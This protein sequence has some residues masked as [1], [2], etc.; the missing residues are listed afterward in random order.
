M[1]EWVK[2][3]CSDLGSPV[4]SKWGKWLDIFIDI[5][6]IK[7]EEPQIKKNIKKYLEIS[8]RKRNNE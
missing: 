1:S 2:C 7:T 3:E 8:Q 4:N 5:Y 6:L